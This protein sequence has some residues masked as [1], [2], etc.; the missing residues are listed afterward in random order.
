MKQEDIIVTVLMS[1]YNHEKYIAQAIESVVSQ[2]TDFKYELLIGED[3]STDD[4]R[5][6]VR[7]YQKKYPDII[8]PLYYKKNV[9]VTMNGYCMLKK[10]QGKYIASCEGDDF[11]CNVRRIQNDVT[12]L[13]KHQEYVGICNK[14]KI[15][16]V[17]GDEITENLDPRASFVQFDKPLYTLKDFSDWR[18]PGHCSTLTTRNI[19]LDE[20]LDYRIIY[21]ASGRVG[22]RTAIMIKAIYGDIFVGEKI[23]SCY[24]YRISSTENNFM[25]LYVNK[26]LRD[27]DF[28]MMRRLESWAWKHKAVHV[29]LEKVK[30]ERFIGSVVVWMKNSTKDNLRVV[31]RII[32]YSGEPVKYIFYAFKIWA[33]KKYY[34]K[35]KKTD[36]MIVL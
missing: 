13:E 27:E 10:A 29:D 2:E 32:K 17:N 24:R 3:C 11:W 16:D 26:N 1:T 9:G 15:V 8:K 4:T 31:A 36:N 25:S 34:W 21:R 28:L 35:I 14:C 5:K 22:D 33:L 23:V 30:K 19:F 12:F 20:K 6:I 7:E 18:L